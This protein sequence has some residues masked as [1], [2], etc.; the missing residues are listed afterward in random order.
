MIRTDVL[1]LIGFGVMTVIQAVFING[2]QISMGEGMILN[3]F[4]NWAVSVSPVFAKPLGS[5]I[6]CMSSVWGAITYWP[7]VVH[8]FGFRILEIPVFL[9][10]VFC[11]VFLN[12]Y[13][14]KKV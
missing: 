5:C 14:Y 4:R 11:L 7:L 3:G 13:F 6:K 9:V 2:V 1:Y 10:D 12:F 8:L